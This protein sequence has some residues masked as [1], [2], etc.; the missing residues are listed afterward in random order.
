MKM[1]CPLGLAV[2]AVLLL[3]C[4][5]QRAQGQIVSPITID[6]FGTPG[7]YPSTIAP[8]PT[9]PGGPA[10]VAY[11]LPFLTIPGDV[12]VGEPPVT[13]QVSSDLLRWVPQQTQTLLFVYSERPEIPST[14]IIGPADV[15]VPPPNTAT[16]TVFV[17]EIGFPFGA[18][19]TDASNGVVYTA[20]GAVPGA[21]TAGVPVTYDFI[22]DA[23]PEPVILFL[24]P[25]LVGLLRRS[26]R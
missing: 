5:S 7:P 16:P 1:K 19:Y 3:A 26:R 22:S 25:A 8:D 18:P 21:A 12:V 4:G 2:G 15:G 10:T 24:T 23:V 9:V 20:V 11:I 17:D 13:T 14:E 6:E